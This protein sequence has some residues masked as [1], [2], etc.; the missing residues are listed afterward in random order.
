MIDVFLAVQ[1]SLRS[2]LGHSELVESTMFVALS[3]G[4][5]KDYNNFDWQA[6]L[7]NV[8]YSPLI[9]NVTLSIKS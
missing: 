7:Y 5:F 2:S 4:K 6:L 9:W 3:S 1:L 8:M